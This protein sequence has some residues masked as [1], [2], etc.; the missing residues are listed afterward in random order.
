MDDNQYKLQAQDYMVALSIIGQTVQQNMNPNSKDADYNK[1]ILRGLT[2]AQEIAQQFIK[3]E[4]KNN[5]P[6]GLYHYGPGFSAY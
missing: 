3:I 1:G 2:M 5:T 4:K 6:E